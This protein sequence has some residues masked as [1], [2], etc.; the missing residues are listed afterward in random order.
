MIVVDTN[1]VSELMRSKPSLA[2]REWVA[3]VAGEQICVTS[4]TLAEILYGIERLPTGRRQSELRTAATDVLSALDDR[5]LPFDSTA[6][7]LYSS[8]VSSRERRG[9]PIGGFDA[10]IASICATHGSV[11]ATRDTTDFQHTG[12][13]VIDPWNDR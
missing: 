5:L 6:A 11:L 3:H 8:I 10:Q 4:V 9:M 7:L 1:V 13:D 12:I 2:L